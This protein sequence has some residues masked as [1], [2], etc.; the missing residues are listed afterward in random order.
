MENLFGPQ[1][2]EW[3]RERLTSYEELYAASSLAYNREDYFLTPEQMP[4]MLPVETADAD[5]DV[6]AGHTA[7][8]GRYRVA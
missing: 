3:L 8:G 2:R 4:K 5:A 7:A 1:L 6:A